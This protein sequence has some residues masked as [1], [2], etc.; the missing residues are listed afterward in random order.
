MN[1]HFHFLTIL[2][3][4]VLKTSQSPL[5]AQTTCIDPSLIDPNAICATI[6]D[7]VCGC[8][9]VTYSNTC[10]AVNYGGVTSWT[11]GVC[12]SNDCFDQCLYEF[13][14]DLNGTSLHAAF[15]FGDI[16]PPF[17]FYV[18]WSLDGGTVTGSGLDFVHL[19]TEPG[20]HMLCASYPTGDFTPETCTVC[21]AFEVTGLCIEPAQIDS[22]VACPLAF[23][24]VCGCDGVTYDNACTAYNYGG[25]SSWKP[26]ACGSVCNELFVDFI[27]ENT[28]GS[29]YEWTFQEESVFPGGNINSWYW[30]F[31]NGLIS[32]EEAPTISFSGPGEYDVCLSVSGFYADGTTCNGIICK[33]IMVAAQTCIDPALIDT[34]V[35]CPAVYVPVCGCNGITY[36]NECV[37]YN[38]HGV[39]TWTS[40]IC[41][42]QCVNPLWIDTTLACIEIYDPVCGCNEVT[43]ANECYAVHYGGVTSWTKGVCCETSACKALFELEILPGNSIL[44]KN[45]SQNAEASFLNFGDGSPL[46]PGVFDT[47]MHTYPAAGPYQI[48]LEISNFAGTCTDTYCYWVHFTSGVSGPGNQEIFMEITPNPVHAQAEVRVIGALPHGAVLFDLLGR[49]VW[50]QSISEPNFEL[51]TE[52]LLTGIYWLHVQT[53]KGP[54]VRKLIVTR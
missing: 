19:L 43:Y 28:G 51:S 15:D 7:P 32:T 9:G 5:C 31:G 13:E 45:L 47:V 6:Y 29:V 22:N 30:D 44:I 54:I 38:Y 50:E 27:G 49:K 36:P 40:G 26:G 41:P 35:F 48:C 12:D 52:N 37:A 23:I 1:K 17:F 11:A 24:P 34:S 3:F 53:D 16:D 14:Y 39:T 46:V 2:G 33:K 8:N 20:I 21:R 4:F 42:D 10:E 25:V 18:N